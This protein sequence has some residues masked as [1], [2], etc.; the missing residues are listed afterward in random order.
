MIP[1]DEVSAWLLKQRD[2]LRDT[3]SDL[4][5]KLKAEPDPRERR[6]L[7][8]EALIVAGQVS[9]VEHIWSYLGKMWVG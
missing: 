1:A 5:A 2:T 4:E 8:D 9:A 3:A 7:A 6:R